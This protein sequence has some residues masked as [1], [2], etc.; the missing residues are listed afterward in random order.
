MFDCYGLWQMSLLAFT[1]NDAVHHALTAAMLV[2]EESVDHEVHEP[3]QEVL[4]HRIKALEALRKELSTQGPSNA[5]LLTVVFLILL[6]KRFMRDESHVV[7]R[8][9]LADLIQ[10]L[11]GWGS[12][13][14]SV[15]SLIL[16][17]DALW[18]GNSIEFKG[19]RTE[20]ANP[21]L[22]RLSTLTW[23]EVE[24]ALRGAPPGFRALAE[25]QLLSIEIIVVVHRI[26]RVYCQR[27]WNRTKAAIGPVGDSSP[28]ESHE[29]RNGDIKRSNH[30]LYSDVRASQAGFHTFQRLLRSSLILFCT[31]FLYDTAFLSNPG[32]LARAELTVKLPA[33]FPDSHDTMVDSCLFWIWDLVLRS[34]TKRNRN[35]SV[36]AD[37]KELESAMRVRFQH[38]YDEGEEKVGEVLGLFSWS[39]EVSNRPTTSWLEKKD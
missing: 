26:T 2:I 37:T 11:G 15:Q 36:T 29:R 6:A 35:L 13:D 14:E 20:P 33:F 16:Q 10:R 25:Q 30:N 23:S 31:A 32:V 19:P 4:Y 18:G 17:C 28:D 38:I 34:W 5:T 1:A 27:A 7:H 22:V 8:K 39:E 24:F 3:S 21:A 9:V 12:V